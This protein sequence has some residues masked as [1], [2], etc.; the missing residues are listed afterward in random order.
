MLTN[1]TVFSFSYN[2][3]FS[4]GTNFVEFFMQ[5]KN[6]S[7]SDVMFIQKFF[8]LVWHLCGEK[9]QVVRAARAV[10]SKSTKTRIHFHIHRV[11]NKTCTALFT[12][13]GRIPH[14]TQS[15]RFLQGLLP[16]ATFSQQQRQTR[17]SSRWQTKA[18]GHQPRIVYHV[19]IS[20][21]TWQWKICHFSNWKQDSSLCHKKEKKGTFPPLHVF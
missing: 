3:W 5:T 12:F 11:A 15:N 8:Q 19:S 13:Q 18:R 6:F 7:S 10:I 17:A 1:A 2:F 21:A 4:D 16:D 20:K 14:T 9:P